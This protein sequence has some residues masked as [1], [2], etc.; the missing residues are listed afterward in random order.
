MYPVGWAGREPRWGPALPRWGEGWELRLGGDFGWDSGLGDP[1]SLP[2]PLSKPQFLPP[3]NTCNARVRGVC[4]CEG[5]GAAGAFGRGG[6]RPGR[7]IQQAA[8]T[9]LHLLLGPPEWVVWWGGGP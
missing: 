9:S 3:K 8:F 7:D 2:Q 4:V 5:A 1:G 6:G